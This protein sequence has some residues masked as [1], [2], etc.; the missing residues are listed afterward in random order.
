MK[1]CPYCKEIAV[2]LKSGDDDSVDFCKFCDKI[3]EGHTLT[4]EEE[5]KARFAR[6]MGTPEIL[7]KA[8][9]NGIDEFYS[10]ENKPADPEEVILKHVKDK[11]S[12]IFQLYMS[13]SGD[14]TD[15]TATAIWEKI[16]K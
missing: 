16:I 13:G 10:S 5:T 3:I 7:L 4:I 9:R 14:L 8:I 15:T 12:Q 2:P 6:A 11:L 1:F